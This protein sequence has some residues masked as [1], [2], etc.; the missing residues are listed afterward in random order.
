MDMY[1]YVRNN[2]LRFTD[3]TG[4]YLCADDNK[5][6]SK[7]TRLLEKARKNDQSQGPAVVAAAEPMAPEHRYG[8]NVK[9]RGHRLGAA[10][11]AG[12]LDFRS[13]F[14]AFSKALSCFELHLLSSAHGTC[15][16][17]Q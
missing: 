6:N 3:P 12:S 13:F 11:T 17:D 10:T 1:S 5:C 15:Q 16:W 4:M 2:P 14:R 9:F 8:R 7:R